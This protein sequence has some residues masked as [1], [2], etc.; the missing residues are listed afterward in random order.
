[1]R[2]SDDTD[3]AAGATIVFPGFSVIAGEGDRVESR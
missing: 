3:A 1:M 2:A